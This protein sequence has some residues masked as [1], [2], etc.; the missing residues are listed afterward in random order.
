MIFWR[1][2]S[3]ALSHHS[4]SDMG[5]GK[6]GASLSSQVQKEVLPWTPVENKTCF[7][8]LFISKAEDQGHLA[9]TVERR[10]V[11]TV[12]VTRSETGILIL[13]DQTVVLVHPVFDQPRVQES[14]F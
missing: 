10:E 6:E 5:Q 14:F 12:A 9:M 2:L 1:R 3:G 4:L 11:A 7:S 13:F 8:Y